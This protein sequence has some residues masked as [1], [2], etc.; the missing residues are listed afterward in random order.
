MIALDTLN[1]A[2]RTQRARRLARYRR[3]PALA[4]TGLE[5]GPMTVIARRVR[6]RWGGP[7]LALMGHEA[8]ILAL[9]SVAYLHPV[10][11][12]VIGHLRRA[13]KAS[14]RG[15]RALATMHLAHTG[16][17]P[18]DEDE[19]TAF[20][21]FAAEMRLDAGECPRQLMHGLGIDA[22]PL[23]AVKYAPAEPSNLHA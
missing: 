10:S 6:D 9:L 8:R 11:P 1:D 12:S 16:L 3:L 4:E 5:L 23:A 17:A 19:P 13:T 18:I 21:L 22:W 14:A 15:D 20:R 2:W 7:D